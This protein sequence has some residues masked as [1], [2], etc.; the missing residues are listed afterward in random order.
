M[1]RESAVEHCLSHVAKEGR[2]RGFQA[3]SGPQTASR[4]RRM[5]RGVRGTP[6]GKPGTSRAPR[7]RSEAHRAILWLLKLIQK[8]TSG[9]DVSNVTHRDVRLNVVLETPE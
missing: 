8:H 9:I 7:A 3:A 6:Q 5:A 1:K 2:K 4:A